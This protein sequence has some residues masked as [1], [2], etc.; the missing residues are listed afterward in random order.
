M[1]LEGV[2]EQGDGLALVGQSGV[3][4]EEIGE[5]DGSSGC[6]GIA[7]C[8]WYVC[9]GMVD[10]RGTPAAQTGENAAC[11]FVPAGQLLSDDQG[12]RFT[13]LDA[14]AQAA[15]LDGMEPDIEGPA[16][17]GTELVLGQ[18]WE[19]RLDALLKTRQ[20]AGEESLAV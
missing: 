11:A 1:T 12:W 18:T 17:Q 15:G 2:L 8:T 5:R 9:H 14:P 6:C 20:V 13:G 10:F 3:V 7:G 4:G 19:E 16:D